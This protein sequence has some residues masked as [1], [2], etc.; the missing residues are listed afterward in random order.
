MNRFFFLTLSKVYQCFH[1]NS[2]LFIK[3]LLKCFLWLLLHLKH[4]NINNLS[5]ADVYASQDLQSVH[6]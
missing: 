1:H 2:N 5:S 3:D 6:L 4:L